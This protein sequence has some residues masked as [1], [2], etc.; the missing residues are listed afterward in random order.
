MGISGCNSDLDA[1]DADLTR[2]PI[3]RSL[4]W[5]VPLVA[6]ANGVW[7]SAMRRSAHMS[8]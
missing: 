6:S 3:L 7:S 4:R 8:T 1:A 5:I 2:A